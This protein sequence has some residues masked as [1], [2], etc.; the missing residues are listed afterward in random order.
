MRPQIESISLLWQNFF[1]SQIYWSFLA[2]FKWH[3]YSISNTQVRG[4]MPCSLHQGPLL[5]NN[6][7]AITE[8]CDNQF[9]KAQWWKIPSSLNHPQT[10]TCLSPREVSR[11]SL[12]VCKH[13]FRPICSFSSWRNS[14]D[15][16]A[17]PPLPL[18]DIFLLSSHFHLIALFSI[19]RLSRA[20]SLYYW[21][22]YPQGL[23]GYS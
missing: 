10:L 11:Q 6:A 1:S 17:S 18:F 16:C 5:Y 7:G 13:R 9:S 21:C 2:R 4:P 15:L 22:N 12:A 20:S 8:V 3:I 14:T 19:C 23:L